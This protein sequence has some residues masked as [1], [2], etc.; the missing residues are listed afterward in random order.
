MPY[1]DAEITKRAKE[2]DYARKTCEMCK[3]VGISEKADANSPTGKV[4]EN[5]CPSCKESGRY[6]SY[7]GSTHTIT[8]DELMNLP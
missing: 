5:P 3:G 7:G 2:K 4:V 1:N 6:W 8:D